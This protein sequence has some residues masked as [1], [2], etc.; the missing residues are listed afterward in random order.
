MCSSRVISTAS[1][2]RLPSEAEQV[3]QLTWKN[4]DT[5]LAIGST[6]SMFIVESLQVPLQDRHETY[7]SGWPSRALTGDP[8]KGWPQE[9]CVVKSGCIVSPRFLRGQS[10]F[11]EAAAG[12]GKV[13]DCVGRALLADLRLRSLDW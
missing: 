1:I 10:V 5:A 11:P 4:E 12:V 13:T 9:D 2:H 8:A 7:G 6:V 3:L